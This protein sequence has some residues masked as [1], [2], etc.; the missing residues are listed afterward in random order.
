MQEYKVPEFTV[1]TLSSQTVLISQE[2]DTNVDIGDL[3]PGGVP[4]GNM[5]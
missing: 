3:F 2:G 4:G 5:N 1:M